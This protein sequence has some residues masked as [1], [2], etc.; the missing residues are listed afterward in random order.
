[1]KVFISLFV[2]LMCFAF[3]FTGPVMAEPVTGNNILISHQGAPDNPGTENPAMAANTT[4][5]LGGVL[6]FTSISNAPGTYREYKLRNAGKAD[7]SRT[8]LKGTEQGG[9]CAA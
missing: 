1:M 2:L 7:L 4:E 5:N 6:K 8:S 9:H 3:I